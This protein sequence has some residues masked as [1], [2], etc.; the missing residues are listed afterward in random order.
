M[1]RTRRFEHAPESVTAARRFVAETL[2]Q[3]PEETR[4]AVTLMVS[5][6]A[7]NCIRHT[8]SGFELTIT[9]A[10]DELW[11]SATDWGGGRPV[12][13]NPA[14]TDPSG[15]GLQIIDMLSDAWGCE[16]EAGGAKTVWL[17]LAAPTTPAVD[18]P[19]SSRA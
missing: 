6:L 11:V 10:D 12:M 2:R 13:R 16:P 18:A 15:R 17:R 9:H 14:P 8:D 19:A 1:R 5:E 3:L 4:D 7:S